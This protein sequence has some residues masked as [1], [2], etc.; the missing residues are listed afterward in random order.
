[1]E[2]SCTDRL[3]CWLPIAITLLPTGRQAQCFDPS[4]LRERGRLSEAGQN[5]QSSCLN[6]KDGGDVFQWLPSYY[7]ANW[8]KC[9]CAVTYGAKQV[10]Y[11]V[12]L[13]RSARADTQRLYKILV[14]LIPVGNTVEWSL[15]SLTL[16]LQVIVYEKGECWTCGQ[17]KSPLIRH[18]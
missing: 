7:S 13:L 2:M 8:W 5:V 17:R 11:T 10:F 18:I 14:L 6:S 15:P 12:L 4:V 16:L 1:M 3:P 9:S